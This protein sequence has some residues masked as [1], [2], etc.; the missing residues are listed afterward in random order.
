MDKKNVSSKH[1]RLNRFSALAT[2]SLVAVGVLAFS[3]PS[4]AGRRSGHPGPVAISHSDVFLFGTTTQVEG[5]SSQLVRTDAAVTVTL[6]T[7]SL[8][9]E[10]VHTLW[11]VVFND[12]G[13]CTAGT[14]GACGLMDLLEGRGTPSL[15]WGAGNVVDDSGA[16]GFAAHLRVGE[17]PGE[18]V[19]GEEQGLLDPW[20]A[21]IHAVVRSHGAPIP[22]QLYEQLHTFVG[23]CDVNGCANLQF[24][25]Y[26]N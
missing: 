7:H 4:D 13:G 10:A 3:N 22:G 15:L 21:E 12:P 8:E 23:G 1:K 9:P 2:C 25:V 11:W 5:A 26:E 18:V 16:G 17:P 14:V 24:V 19:R 6:Q 20:G